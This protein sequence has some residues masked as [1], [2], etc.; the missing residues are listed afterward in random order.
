MLASFQEELLKN[1]G[2]L[3]FLAIA[4]FGIQGVH[5]FVLRFESTLLLSPIL[6]FPVLFR[7]SS[8]PMVNAA[9]FVLMVLMASQSV[10]LPYNYT[11]AFLCGGLFHIISGNYFSTRQNGINLQCLAVAAVTVLVYALAALMR[12]E[13]IHLMHLILTFAAQSVM[14]LL[15]TKY[16]A[17]VKQ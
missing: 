17:Y 3:V 6:L 9:L 7:K 5:L 2:F 10:L 16:M 11:L 14:I 1:G 8:V 15:S 4:V 12:N 13:T